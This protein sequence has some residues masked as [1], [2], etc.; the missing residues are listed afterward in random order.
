MSRCSRSPGAHSTAG[1]RGRAPP[2]QAPRRAGTKS[3][4]RLDDLEA[5]SALG[6]LPIPV[7]NG[8]TVTVEAAGEVCP[9][10]WYD[11]RCVGP[12]GVNGNRL[13]SYNVLES[14]P[15]AALVGVMPQG[16][17][18]IGSSQQL[19]VEQA[20]RL[21]LFVNDEDVSN[22]RGEFHVRVRTSG[23]AAPSSPRDP[24]VGSPGLRIDPPR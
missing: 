23:G 15:H 20:G 5:G 2:P 12:D 17:A 7:W 14:L 19:L 10:S 1:I 18:Y 22:N 8:D 11:T 4:L 21:L 6:W 3:T 16:R 9:S 13:S 24:V